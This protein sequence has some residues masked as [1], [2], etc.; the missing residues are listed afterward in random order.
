MSLP[1]GFLDELHRL[2]A[3]R[4]STDAADLATYGR[5]W[6]KVHTPAPGAIAFPRSTEEVAASEATTFNFERSIFM[7]SF[8]SSA[9]Q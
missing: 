6:T 3:D 5:D 1:A 4:V 8:F 2:G 9:L 7:V